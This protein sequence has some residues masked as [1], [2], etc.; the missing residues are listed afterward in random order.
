MLA[1]GWRFKDFGEEGGLGGSFQQIQGRGMLK[2]ITQGT[3]CRGRRQ[4]SRRSQHSTP[5]TG[6]VEILYILVFYHFCSRLTA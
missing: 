2:Q 4:D 3:S 5:I 6:R 1:W